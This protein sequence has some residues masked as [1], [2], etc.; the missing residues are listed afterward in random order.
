MK[1][2][3]KIVAIA[4]F[5]P[6]AA[7]AQF[8][9]GTGKISDP[10]IITTAAQLAELA[11]LVNAG[12]STYNI[13]YYRLGA[14]IDLSPYGKNYNNGEGWI[15]IGINENFP[16]GGAFDGAG[17]T[18][19]NLYINVSI[20][21]SVPVGLFGYVEGGRIQNVG[22]P[23]VEIKGSYYVGSVVGRIKNGSITSCYSTGGVRGSSSVG[24]VLGECFHS[25]ITNCYST[26]TIH[27]GFG[28]AGGVAGNV[29]DNSSIT[30]CYATGAVSGL[31]GRIGGVVGNLSNSRLSNCA[32]LNPLVISEAV[33]GR[34]IGNVYNSEVGYCTSFDG[35]DNSYGT[36][37]WEHADRNGTDI[38]L[39]AINADE[40]IGGVFTG[41]PWTTAPGKLP[42]LFGQTV[43]MPDY[44]EL[45]TVSVLANPPE[46]G[47]V[48][49][50]NVYT[51][52]TTTTVTATANPDYRFMNWTKDGYVVSTAAEYTF[53]LLKSATL[54]ANF[55][56]KSD[57]V[58]LITVTVDG[59]TAVRSGNSFSVAAC[60][61]NATTITVEPADPHATV[62]I[63][64]VAQNPLAINLPATYGSY[65]ITIKVTAQNG[66]NTQDYTLTMHEP[67]AFDRIV[68]V[69][70]DNTLAVNNNPTNN[71]GHTFISYKWF[72]NGQEV[73]TQQWLSA[74]IAGELLNP[75]DEYSVEAITITGDTIR[76]CPAHITLTGMGVKVYPNPMNGGQIFYLEANVDA[77]LLNNAVIEVYSLTGSQIAQLKP[78]GRITP[79]N[80]TLTPGVYIVVLTNNK[81]FRKEL[82]IIVN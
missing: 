1:K 68:K 46:G 73:G 47:S 13:A 71:G 52:P 57:N 66:I 30:N 53:R 77:A 27:C 14:D 18:I 39:F 55:E 38:D 8:S 60:S 63:N 49:G 6:F 12:G 61:S 78:Q 24:G 7:T 48:A 80:V 22:I 26:A 31:Q 33:N 21:S 51:S 76:T 29:E 75:A 69:R 15:S 54:V 5:L 67:L 62:E 16:F 23:N 11:R 10:Y 9:S 70:W 43:E 81:G 32:A 3:L 79:I 40:T 19:S 72:R 17:H 56:K 25:N 36:T 35:M 28:V 82:K 41:A 65:S 34:V 59:H 37:E 4:C 58:E 42:G 50:G 2:R 45:Y 44:L 20:S 74:G 64:G